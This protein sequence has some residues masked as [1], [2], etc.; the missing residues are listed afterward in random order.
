MKEVRRCSQLKTQQEDLGH[1]TAAHGLNLLL[2]SLGDRKINFNLN[3]EEKPDLLAFTSSAWPPK[4]SGFAGSAKSSQEK[5]LRSR[6]QLF[7]AVV[8]SAATYQNFLRTFKQM[9]GVNAEQLKWISG[10]E[11]GHE[12][13]FKVPQM[14]V[15][16]SQG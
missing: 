7:S 9:Q 10:A 13:F 14:I 8:L 5:R 6:P 11:S 16:S 3:E 1:R 2:S 15:M 4:A 12:M